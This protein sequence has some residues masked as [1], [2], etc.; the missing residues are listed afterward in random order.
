M[1]CGPRAHRG[2]P[3]ACNESVGGVGKENVTMEIATHRKQFPI[4]CSDL[5]F[6]SKE[7]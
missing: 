5:V 3:R 4:T 7:L 6:S 1:K 2:P